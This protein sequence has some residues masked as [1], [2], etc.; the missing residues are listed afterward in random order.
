MALYFNLIP[1]Q[2]HTRIYETSLVPNILTSQRGFVRFWVVFTLILAMY[3][4]TLQP[5]CLCFNASAGVGRVLCEFDW[6][7]EWVWLLYY[8]T[9]ILIEV[10]L[11]VPSTGLHYQLKDGFQVQ[12]RKVTFWVQF[13]RY[14][15]I[16][17]LI[18]SLLRCTV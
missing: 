18:T 6:Q 4:A 16:R 15:T 9:D 5:Y 2:R 12:M 14:K 3:S 7:I 11:S 13:G 1:F 8:M 17:N 10:R